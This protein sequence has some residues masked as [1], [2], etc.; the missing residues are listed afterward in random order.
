MRVVAL[1]SARC[2]ARHNPMC[3]DKITQARN[4]YRIRGNSL[5][6]LCS[7]SELQHAVC[8]LTDTASSLCSDQHLV[9][10]D[11]P[12]RSA[13][14]TQCDRG[15]QYDLRAR[16]EMRDGNTHASD[17]PDPPRPSHAICAHTG[18]QNTQGP[19]TPTASA[20]ATHHPL[21]PTPPPPSPLHPPTHPGPIHAPDTLAFRR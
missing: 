17:A 21:H 7:C 10:T 1:F 2:I 18:G 19:P 11:C 9:P 16:R 15:L 6:R 13:R 20:V 5:W 14:R 12:K 3:V 4:A 8:H